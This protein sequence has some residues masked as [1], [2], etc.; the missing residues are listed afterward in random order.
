MV[1]APVF[2]AAFQKKLQELIIWRRDV[3]HFKTDEIPDADVTAILQSACLSPSVG[4]AQPW[5]FVM[6]D[7][8]HKREEVRVSYLEA[9]A[10]AL[11]AYNGEQA[12]A[13]AKLKLSG[14]DQAPVHFGVFAVRDPAEGAGLGRQTMPQAVQYSVAMALQTMF[15]VAR[16]KGIGMGLV[17][18]IDPAE[19]CRILN[20][21]ADWDLIS[22]VCMGYPQEEHAVPELVREKWQDTLPLQQFVRRV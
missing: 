21:P 14:M 2:D 8:A 6:V 12:Q 16:A 18:I 1:N 4:N 11:M 22:Y 7:S 15:L 19:V 20:V 13:Y 17:T 5:R 9:N 10:Q 3:R